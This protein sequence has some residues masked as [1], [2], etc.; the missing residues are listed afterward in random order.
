MAHFDD[1][2][3]KIVMQVPLATGNRCTKFEHSK[4]ILSLVMSPDDLRLVSGLD[5]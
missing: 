3:L 2:D 1:L 5:L 4:P